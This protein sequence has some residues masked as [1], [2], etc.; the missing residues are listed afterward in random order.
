MTASKGA[1]WARIQANLERRAAAQPPPA[2]PPVP[3][4]LIKPVPQVRPQLSR[5]EQESE[6]LRLPSSTS[7]ETSQPSPSEPRPAPSK[8]TPSLKPFVPPEAATASPQD[9]AV[10]IRVEVTNIRPNYRRDRGLFF[11][12]RVRDWGIAIYDY[13]LSWQNGVSQVS[14][15]SR[16][17]LDVN[18]QLVLKPDGKPLYWKTIAFLDGAPKRAF[19][20]AVVEALKAA[21]PATFEPPVAA[22]TVASEDVVEIRTR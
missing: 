12:V 7:A 21:S 10:A 8:A 13:S 15:P 1:L 6:I 22:E 18:R 2:P 20:A 5:R 16:A 19:R 3:P 14:S 4:P 9:A 11:D 17:H